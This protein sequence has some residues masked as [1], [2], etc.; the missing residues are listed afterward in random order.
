MIIKPALHSCF[1][2][3]VPSHGHVESALTHIMKDSWYL[4][5]LYLKSPCKKNF[6]SPF[7]VTLT[8]RKKSLLNLQ[9][10]VKLNKISLPIKTHF[11]PY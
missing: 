4:G 10:C 7:L 6:L 11:L 2:S 1:P 5:Y 9:Q 8:E 3:E